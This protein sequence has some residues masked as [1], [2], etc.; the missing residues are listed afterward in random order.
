M[1]A[2]DFLNPRRCVWGGRGVELVNG[3]KNVYW[4]EKLNRIVMKDKNSVLPQNKTLTNFSKL[5][6]H[7]KYINSKINWTE[8][9]AHSKISFILISENKQNFSWYVCRKHFLLKQNLLLRLG[10]NV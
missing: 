10:D 4:H 3:L 8:K 2:L 5:V 1:S 7:Q 9:N 6:Q